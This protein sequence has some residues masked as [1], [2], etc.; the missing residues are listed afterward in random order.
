MFFLTHKVK[1]GLENYSKEFF[2]GNRSIA[3]ALILIDL[4]SAK[5][6]ENAFQPNV[7]IGNNSISCYVLFTLVSNLTC[8]CS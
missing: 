8:I 2:I 4:D 7:R 5:L 1:V 3:N 6:H